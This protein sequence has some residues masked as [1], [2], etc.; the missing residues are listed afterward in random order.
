M[1]Y[2]TVVSGAMKLLNALD[3]FRNDGSAASNA[4]LREGLSVL[5]RALYPACPHITHGAVAAS[6]ALPPSSATCST[7]PGRRSTR[8]RWC[9]TRSS[10][11]C[12]ST[13]RR[14]ARSACRP[15]PTRPAIEAAALASPEFAKFAEG[16]PAKK[17]VIVPGR[18]VNV[19]V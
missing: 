12:R 14:A 19:V 4:A 18:L 13:A 5:L 6:S 3:E 17:V 11:C 15:R 1:Q 7:R 10:W 9:R 2:N 16:K 8:P